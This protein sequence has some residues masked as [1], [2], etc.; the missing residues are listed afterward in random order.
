MEY[1]EVRWNFRDCY[2]MGFIIIRHTGHTRQ[3]IQIEKGYLLKLLINVYKGN[4]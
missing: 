1:D 4:L 2:V 3:C